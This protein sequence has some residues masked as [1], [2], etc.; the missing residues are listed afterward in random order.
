MPIDRSSMDRL[1]IPKHRIEVELVLL[2]AKARRVAVFLAECASEHAGA[3]RLSDVLNRGVE[4]L[5]AIGEGDRPVFIGTQA[6]GAAVV[7]AAD[8]PADD[9]ALPTECE[10]TVT[11]IDGQEL[12]GALSFVQPP[13]RAR[14]IDFLNDAPP[15]FPLVTGGRVAL[16]HKRRV[17]QVTPR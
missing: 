6:I 5:P 10:V 1:R 4:F 2:G 8:E 11:L 7:S 12:S 17:A 3:E 15:F 16:I 9:A 14:A 13:D